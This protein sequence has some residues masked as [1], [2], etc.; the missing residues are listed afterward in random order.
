MEKKV[1]VSMA[2]MPC[3]I[4]R[5]KENLPSIL[6]QSYKFDKLVINVDDKNDVSENDLMFYNSL[7]NEIIEIN[8][9]KN[10]WRSC[11]KLLPTLEKYPEDIIIT[12]D[13][14]IYYPID[15]FK[16]LIEQYNKTPDCIIAHEVHPLIIKNNYITYF[17]GVDIKLKQ[18]EWGKYLSACCLFP[19]HVF[20]GTE[21]YNFDKMMECTNGTHDELWFWINS[22]LNGVQCVGL[23][24]V[25]S[26]GVETLT[27]Y[28]DDEFALFKINCNND[29]INAYMDI[30]NKNYGEKLLKQIKNKDVVFNIDENNIYSYFF[31][32]PYINNFYNYGYKIECSTLTKAW[33]TKLLN[34]VKNNTKPSL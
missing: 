1:I 9:C 16:C 4:K 13:D 26:F 14:D 15:S 2:T 5:L 25:F 28:S 31:L 12:I 8:I 20:D 19:P 21:L 29:A 24:Y 22:T 6:N 7:K 10:K 34:V 30:I 17:N 23:N 18:K 33:K 3:R 27:P 32:L 11:N